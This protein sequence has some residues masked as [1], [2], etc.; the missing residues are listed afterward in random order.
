MQVYPLFHNRFYSVKM[1]GVETSN[2]AAQRKLY[3]ENAASVCHK[4]YL[5]PAIYDKFSKKFVP[6]NFSYKSPEHIS[7]I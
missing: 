3:Q 6:M 7:E 5:Y 1:V 2:T 4:F